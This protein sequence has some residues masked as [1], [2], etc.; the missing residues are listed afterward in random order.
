MT[1]K[2][3]PDRKKQGKPRETGAA[4]R[5]DDKSGHVWADDAAKARTA[6]D[7]RARTPS[8]SAGQPSTRSFEE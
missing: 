7:P 4:A 1:E 2:K 5:R 3:N 8:D 6:G